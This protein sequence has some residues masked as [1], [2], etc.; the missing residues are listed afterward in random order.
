VH[1]TL[2]WV[3]HGGGC[4]GC[5]RRLSGFFL[6]PTGMGVVSFPLGGGAARGDD[7]QVLRARRGWDVGWFLARLDIGG[8][9]WSGARVDGRGDFGPCSVSAMWC[10]DWVGFGSFYGVGRCLFACFL[11]G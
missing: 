9:G 11:G 7:A 3:V 6:P 1:A 5:S 10:L 8:R 2:W 4:C